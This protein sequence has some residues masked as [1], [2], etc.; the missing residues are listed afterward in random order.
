M[1]IQFVL[2]P[3]FVEVLLT[4]GVMFGMMFFRTSSLQRGETRLRDIA[5][6]EP[7]WP[8]RATQ[9]G[10]AFANQFELPVLFYVLTIL[11][12]VTRHA[13]L[14]FVFLAWIFVVM[15]VLQAWVHVTNN[16]VRARGAFYGVGAIILVIMWVIYI[17]RILLALP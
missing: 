16:N 12:I 3:L 6:R 1:P 4:F 17:V 7:N 15:R 9:F 5:L 2:L 13:D 14:L 10:Y 11:E 8:V